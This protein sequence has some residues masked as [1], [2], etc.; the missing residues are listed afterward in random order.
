MPSIRRESDALVVED[1]GGFTDCGRQDLGVY[2]CPFLDEHGYRCDFH[3]F[4]LFSSADKRRREN[5]TGAMGIGFTSVYQVTDRPELISGRLHWVIDETKDQ[6]EPNPRDR[7]RHASPWHAVR[8]SL[9][10]R[11]DERIPSP[12]RGCRGSCGR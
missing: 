3:S 9:G 10:C 5:T 8:S 4:R 1:D 11:P 7:A 2:A 6:D 12:R